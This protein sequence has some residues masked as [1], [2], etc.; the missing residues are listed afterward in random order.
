MWTYVVHPAK[1]WFLQPKA[2]QHNDAGSNAAEIDAKKKHSQPSMRQLFLYHFFM[3]WRK[4]LKCFW[5]E[6]VSLLLMILERMWECLLAER[7]EERALWL[8]WVRDTVRHSG[9]LW[10][11]VIR[12]WPLVPLLTEPQRNYELMHNPDFTSQRLSSAGTRHRTN[13]QTASSNKPQREKSILR[14]SEHIRRDGGD[15][16]MFWVNNIQTHKRTGTLSSWG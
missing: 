7:G 2:E 15:K 9:N 8:C 11:A 13:I 5:R 12:A 16:L 3:H 14:H 10:A 4:M 1:D 6:S